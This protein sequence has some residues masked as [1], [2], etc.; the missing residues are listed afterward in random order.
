M[1]LRGQKEILK[2]VQPYFIPITNSWEASH[3][4]STS[5]LKHTSVEKNILE[6]LVS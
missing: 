4:T 5:E 1:W 6:T 3:S 2:E